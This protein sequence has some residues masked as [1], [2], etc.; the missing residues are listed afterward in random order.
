MAELEGLE[1]YAEAPAE[2][3]VPANEEPEDLARLEKTEVE[4]GSEAAG[5]AGVGASERRGLV[6]RL[7]C[8]AGADLAVG[9]AVAVAAEH[10]VEAAGAVV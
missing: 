3:S 5:L 2:V 7:G 6:H 10:N 9:P 1:V 4:E 8:M